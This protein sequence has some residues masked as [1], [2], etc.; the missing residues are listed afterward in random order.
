MFFCQTSLFTYKLRTNLA[1][2]C[3]ILA[4]GSSLRARTLTVSKRQSTGRSDLYYFK[5]QVSEYPLRFHLPSTPAQH[6]SVGS[7]SVQP[8]SCCAV[9]FLPVATHTI[10]LTEE[11]PLLYP[12]RAILQARFAFKVALLN[13]TYHIL[14]LNRFPTPKSHVSLLAFYTH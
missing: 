1:L 2:L 7:F 6:L 4:N 14:V 3:P 13:S 9:H 10:S 5:L 12:R 8:Q 11:A